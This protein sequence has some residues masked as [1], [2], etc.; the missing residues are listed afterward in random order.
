[1]RTQAGA[2]AAHHGLGTIVRGFDVAPHIP[3]AG[4]EAPRAG[5][6]TQSGMLTKTSCLRL[7][8]TSVMETFNPQALFEGQPPPHGETAAGANGDFRQWDSHWRPSRYKPGPASKYGNMRSCYE[9]RHNNT[10]REMEDVLGSTVGTTTKGAGPR[11]SPHGSVPRKPRSS[12]EH[13]PSPHCPG[14]LHFLSS[15]A[16]SLLF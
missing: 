5:C 16:K 9:L 7:T 3:P 13:H 15:M 14:L 11:S 8:A 6:D 12:K 1:M 2:S 4:L 10:R